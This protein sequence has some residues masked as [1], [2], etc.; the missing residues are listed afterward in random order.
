MEAISKSIFSKSHL[1]VMIFIVYNNL[2]R[3]FSGFTLN[4]LRAAPAT[5]ISYATH[6]HLR[7]LLGVPRRS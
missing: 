6:D 7:N 2:T 4:V 5:A 1:S 3:Y